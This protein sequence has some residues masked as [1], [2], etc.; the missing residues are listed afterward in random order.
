MENIVLKK[1]TYGNKNK[2]KNYIEII[3]GSDEKF[4][5]PV[6]VSMSSIREHN[7][8]CI[9]HWFVTKLDDLD[10]ERVKRFSLEY[11]VVCNIYYVNQKLVES[12]PH[13]EAWSPAMYYRILAA[14]YFNNKVRRVLYL[15]GDTYCR[16]DLSQLYYMNLHDNIVAAVRDVFQN[17]EAYNQRIRYIGHTG[18]GYFNSGV[19][20]IDI[21]RWNNER[22][23]EK[24]LQ[25]LRENPSRWENAPDQDVLNVLL[26][27]K[28]EWANN[29]YN[30]LNSVV[31]GDVETA[32]II[33][34]AGPKPW[35]A[36]YIG[37]GNKAF[38]I[39]YY[40][41]MKRSKWKD[42]PLQQPAKTV[43]YRYMS[44]KAFKN[45]SLLDGLRWQ[46]RYLIHKLFKN[47]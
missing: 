6:G 47:I 28:V 35:K 33:H 40:E 14:L 12:F 44:K 10:L 7:Q 46:I 3:Y 36:W 2:D 19:L 43:E 26:A 5:R 29:K 9:F 45:G 18:D 41:T 16:G 4:A 39:E 25:Y 42:V 17:Q 34:F 31:Y 38:D 11:N 37:E 30:I 20:L 21:E 24:A 27:N 13:N 23:T 1:L 15:D 22:I 32:G 8:N